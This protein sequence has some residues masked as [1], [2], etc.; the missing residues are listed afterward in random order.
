MR[1][2]LAGSNGQQYVGMGQN[3]YVYMYIHVFL[4]NILDH[5]SIVYLIT[6]PSNSSFAFPFSQH[7]P[8]P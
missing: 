8:M 5:F 2:N 7:R 1:T 4:V 3:L 6:V